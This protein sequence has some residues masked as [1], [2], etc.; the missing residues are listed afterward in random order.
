MSA[1]HQNT[2]IRHCAIRTVCICPYT[3]PS[4]D[5]RLPDRKHC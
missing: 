4:R 2:S 5:L 1:G 3:V